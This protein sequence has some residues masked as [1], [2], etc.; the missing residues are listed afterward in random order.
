MKTQGLLNV[1]ISIF[2]YFSRSLAQKQ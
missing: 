1:K 2:F